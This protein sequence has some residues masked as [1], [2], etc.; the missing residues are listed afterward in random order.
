MVAQ[1]ALT[2]PNSIYIGKVFKNYKEL[3]LELA[4]P[5]KVG[6][7]K[8][9]QLKQFA[10]Y[11]DIAK[12][13][14]SYIILD[15]YLS[16]REK[17]RKIT[18]STMTKTFCILES[19][20]NDLDFDN[21]FTE[22]Y[23]TKKDLQL[24]LGICNETFYENKKYTRKDCPTDIYAK[25]I[26]ADVPIECAINFYSETDSRGWKQ[27]NDLIVNLHKQYLVQ[28]EETYAIIRK[29]DSSSIHSYATKEEHTYIREA[30]ALALGLEK[31]SRVGKE[32]EVL[33]MTES[34]VYLRKRAKELAKDVL[35]NVKLKELNIFAYYKVYKF[36]FSQ[37]IVEITEKYGQILGLKDDFNRLLNVKAL[38]YH[39]EKTEKNIDKCLLLLVKE[40]RKS[41]DMPLEDLVKTSYFFPLRKFY[42]KDREK[43]I[44]LLIDTKREE[45]KPKKTFGIQ[46]NELSN[47]STKEKLIIDIVANERYLAKG[48]M[49]E[50]EKEG[51]FKGYILNEFA[52]IGWLCSEFDREVKERYEEGVYGI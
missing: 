19:L 22:T 40:M 51:M 48:E 16:V 39:S 5:I 33:R 21:E 29:S 25:T 30:I 35:E 12:N 9:A 37:N 36:R 24:L 50:Q 32:H 4:V 41:I 43:L 2:I 26:F 46:L 31:Y 11:M 18:A 7:A 44:K 47:M 10:K 38:K 14:N 3:C 6:N 23:R 34:E 1:T 27:I 20:M 15:I 13:G 52:R 49:V 28:V 8:L 17:E 42:E 45:G